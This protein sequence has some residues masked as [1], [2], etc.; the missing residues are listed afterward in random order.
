MEFVQFYPYRIYSP[1]TSDIFPDIFNHGAKFVNHLGQRFM[2]KYPKKELENRDVLARE[3]YAQKEVRLD[4]SL[5][6]LDFLDKEAPSLARLY[7]KFSQEPFLVR[8]VT[9]FT[10][11]GLCVDSF[12]QTCVP[13]LLAAGE[14]T[15][16]L[17]GANRL[18]G[19]AL[20]ETVVF[21]RRCGLKAAQTALDVSFCHSNMPLPPL[22]E[23]G[24]DEL[25]DII[26]NLRALMWSKVGLI[27]DEN[28]LNEALLSIDSLGRELAAR[29]PAH[30]R[31]FK[32]VSR[33][34]AMARLIVKAA[35]NR[36]ESRGAHYRSDFPETREEFHGSFVFQ[37]SNMTFQPV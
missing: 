21:G 7:E 3:I 24:R 37:R 20:S 28:G 34:L 27:R 6:D 4:L 11:G 10:M 12:G 32:K 22:P 19:H 26:S 30:L 2:E 15:G 1:M 31:A 17:H 5:V 25:K 8:P 36:Q 23:S 14:V 29:K 9:H 13:G 16:G 18:A 33:A 35:L